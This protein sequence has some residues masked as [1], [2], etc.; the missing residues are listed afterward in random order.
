VLERVAAGERKAEIAASL[1]IS[2]LTIRK[3]LENE[4]AK[5]GVENRTAAAAMMS[6]GP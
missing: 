1:G 5:L 2:P 3:H 4:F 6:T